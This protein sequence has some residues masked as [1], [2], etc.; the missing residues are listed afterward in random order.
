VTAN[1]DSKRVLI[2]DRD[3]VRRGMLACT[4]PAHLFSLE[5]ASTPEKGLDLLSSLQPEIVIVGNDRD[6][7]DFCRRIRSLLAGSTFALLLMDERFRD[8]TIGKT[9]SDAAGAD[10]YLPFPFAVEL[11]E[12]RLKATKA[13][14]ARGLSAGGTA[15]AELDHDAKHADTWQRFGKLVEQIHEQL[16]TVDYYQ[17]LRVDKNSASSVIKEAYFYW[18][19]HFHPDRFMRLSDDALKKKIYGIFKRMSE[20]FKVLI[21]PE[22]RSR[23]DENLA[24]PR[25]ETSLRYLEIERTPDT[26]IDPTAE[27]TTAVG[28][29]YLHFATLAESEG[30]LRSALKYLTQAIQLEPENQALKNRLEDVKRKLG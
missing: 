14:T 2:V 22:A 12:D 5:F 8:A 16:D 24:G 15:R 9:E 28:K 26:L 19:L 27:A 21:N 4:L 6:A 7:T 13:G 3:N 30:N 1:S 25:R 10:S 23:Y 17:L 11:L 18:S 29:R 20:A